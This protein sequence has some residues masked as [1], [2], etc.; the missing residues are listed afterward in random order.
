MD[1]TSVGDDLEKLIDHDEF[2]SWITSVSRLEQEA[3]APS[4]EA[5]L[6]SALWA[7]G[8]PEVKI[9]HR[10]IR[11]ELRNGSHVMAFDL[12][13]W[14]LVNL[15]DNSDTRILAVRAALRARLFRT[16]RLLMVDGAH[17]APPRL[18]GK[19]AKLWCDM[20]TAEGC[21]VGIRQAAVLDPANMSLLTRWG[22]LLWERGEHVSARTAYRRST[23]SGTAP[24]KT[25]FRAISRNPGG[26][27]PEEGVELLRSALEC[28][29][30]SRIKARLLSELL[31]LDRRQEA[32]ALLLTDG[33]WAVTSESVEARDALVAYARA[34]VRA[35]D[36]EKRLTA[37]DK[38]TSET[39]MAQHQSGVELAAA[40]W[41]GSA[42]WN[43]QKAI[44]GTKPV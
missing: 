37:S 38:R 9:I 3:R 1:K 11:L 34:Q 42:A 27:G 13:E 19:L 17:A 36:A 7:R 18:A 28:G 2:E 33:D 26:C 15:P 43:L 21:A 5:G 24:A 8:V 31:G 39:V 41:L 16:A 4:S 25:Y 44:S 6:M 20:A 32:L 23:Y 14:A 12:A 10:L 35:A 22:N 40:G 30:D 29:A